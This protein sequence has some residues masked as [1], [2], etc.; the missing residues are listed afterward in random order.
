MVAG[1]LGLVTMSLMMQVW[2]RMVHLPQQQEVDPATVPALTLALSLLMASVVAGV[3]EEAGFRGYMQGPI[4]R[5]H[6]PVVAI[7]VTGT[8][9]G[10]A[11]FTHPEVGLVLMPFYL[12]VA[13]VYGTMAYLTDSILPSL[14]LHAVSDAWG[15][16]GFFV[17][18]QSEWQA[19]RIPTPLIWETGPDPA[20]WASVAGF[21][22]IGAFAVWAYVALSR[23][24]RLARAEAARGG[25]SRG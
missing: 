10:F 3:A 4:E 6:G 24:A 7:L 1:V 25:G 20:F 22:V 13:A 19:S 5:R 9:F 16:I 12:A 15:F 23:L 14:V 17:T 21:I 11:H 18:G 8:F 2:N